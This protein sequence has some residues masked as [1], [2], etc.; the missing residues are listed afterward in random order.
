MSL[1]AAL[2][3]AMSGLGIASKSTELISSNIANA[4]NPTYG[5]RTLSVSSRAM[6]YGGAEINAINRAEKAA[7]HHEFRTSLG[8]VQSGKIASDFLNAARRLFGSTQDGTS[9]T[10]K[11]DTLRAKSADGGR[12]PK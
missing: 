6:S 10:N 3:N 8:H 9:I 12:G 5:R 7:V 11:I 2:S 4:S 1:G